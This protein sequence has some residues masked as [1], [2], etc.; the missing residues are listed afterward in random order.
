M[1]RIPLNPAGSVNAPMGSR[2]AERG[3]LKSRRDDMIIT[4]GKRSVARGGE[5]AK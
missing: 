5:D 1:H 4:P 2:G 3:K